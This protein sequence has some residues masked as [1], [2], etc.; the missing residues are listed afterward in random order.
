MDSVFTLRGAS[1]EGKTTGLQA[2]ASVWGSPQFLRP[3][4]ATGN[5]I[6]ALAA[7]QNDTCMVLDELS[8]A[9][10]FEVGGMVLHG[11]QW[12]RQAAGGCA[13]GGGR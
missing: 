8:Q 11:G 9:S 12:R 13:L 7:S 6:E 1:G 5:G 2:A 4:S 3:W 10:P